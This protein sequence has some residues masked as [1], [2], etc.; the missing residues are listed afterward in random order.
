MIGLTRLVLAV[1]SLALAFHAV[2]TSTFAGENRA[3]QTAAGLT[4]TLYKSEV[5]AIT[6]DVF[7]LTSVIRNEGQDGTPPLIANLAFVAIDGST[8]VD[9]EDWSSERTLTA[10]P[11]APRSSQPLTWEVKTVL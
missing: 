11:I 3:P 7:T 2:A 1:V 6:G 4:V 5:N 10:G 9:P 8:Y